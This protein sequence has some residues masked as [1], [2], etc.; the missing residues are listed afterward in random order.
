LSC[1]NTAS[2]LAVLRTF[3]KAQ[4]RAV[5]AEDYDGSI[6]ERIRVHPTT[7]CPAHPRDQQVREQHPSLDTE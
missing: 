7:G 1:S 3:I 2:Q 5:F 6:G 4:P